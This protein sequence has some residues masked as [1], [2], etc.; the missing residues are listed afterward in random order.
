MPTHITIASVEHEPQSWHQLA[1]WRTDKVTRIVED[2]YDVA[3]QLPGYVGFYNG[4]GAGASIEEHFH[5][6]FFQIPNGHGPFPLQQVAGD[7]EEQTKNVTF[8]TDNISTLVIDP[9]DYPLTAFRFCTEREKMV[10]AVVERIK[11]WN[12]VAGDSASAN[13]VAIWEKKPNWED[14]KL[15]IYLIPRNRFY[16]RSIGM[17]GVVGGLETL[18][19]F[20]F[21]TEEENRIINTQGIDFDYMSS[22]LRGVM[23]PNVE[24]LNI[25]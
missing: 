20:I 16:S 3:I 25:K 17:A 22:I 5:F 12:D 9:Q 24:R 8:L 23:P 11:K 10:S 1:A 4:V 15:V 14:K 6:Q 13:I 21:C 7:V 2:L 19:E 18:G